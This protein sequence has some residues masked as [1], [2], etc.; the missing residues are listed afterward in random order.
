MRA[1]VR[2]QRAKAHDV[3]IGAKGT[4]H[5]PRRDDASQAVLRRAPRIAYTGELANRKAS[6]DRT[7]VG[8][9]M[10]APL[11]GALA[12]GAE[13]LPCHPGIPERLTGSSKKCETVGLR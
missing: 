10:A 3:G 9:D 5:G 1:A 12:A 8:E 7:R 2:S 6:H 11:H 4:R 13:H